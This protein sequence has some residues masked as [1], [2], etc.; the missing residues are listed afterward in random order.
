MRSAKLN[1]KTRLKLIVQPGHRFQL[2]SYPYLYRVGLTTTIDYY[3]SNI[4][5][6]EWTDNIDEVNQDFD[7][8]LAALEAVEE[9][10]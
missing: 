2:Q 7:R 6:S 10:T 3:P 1:E 9:E 8:L 5:L 4:Y